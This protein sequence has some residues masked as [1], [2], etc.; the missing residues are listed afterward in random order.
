L[1]E[2]GNTSIFGNNRLPVIILSYNLY[3]IGTY[4]NNSLFTN[5]MY[6]YTTDKHIG[7]MSYGS[8]ENDVIIIM[9]KYGEIKLNSSVKIILYYTSDD[10]NANTHIIYTYG[11][12]I[13]CDDLHFFPL[14]L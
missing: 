5:H 11:L 6:V 12:L 8:S 13:E 4:T 9:I 10:G 3:F 1:N 7:I 2:F 14:I